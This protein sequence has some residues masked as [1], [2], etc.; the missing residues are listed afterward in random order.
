[1]SLIVHTGPAG[2]DDADVL[3]ISRKLNEKIVADGW[4]DGHRGVALHFCPSKRLQA[5]RWK[6][7]RFNLE[8]ETEDEWL[9]YEQEYTA[10]MRESYRHNRVAW[11][12]LL[13]W[14]RVVIVSREDNAEKSPRVVLA[15]SILTK[16]GAQYMGEL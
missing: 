13:S 7:C 8:H 11:D 15:R 9:Q 5:A 1:V 6:R 2:C 4:P 3:I 14:Q 16:L 12:T 10:E